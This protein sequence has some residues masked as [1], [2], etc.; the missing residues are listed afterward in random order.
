MSLWV[1]IPKA[2]VICFFQ[3]NL[4]LEKEKRGK[5][6]CWLFH[7]SYKIIAVFVSKLPFEAIIM[8]TSPIFFKTVFHS[9]F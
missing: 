1:K 2:F 6:R 9:P 8:I 4:A 3:K 7:R 5:G